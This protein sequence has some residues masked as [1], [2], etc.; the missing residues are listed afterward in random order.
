[1]GVAIRLELL[2]NLLLFLV[3]SKQARGFQCCQARKRLIIGML[4]LILLSLPGFL[5]FLSK[6]RE[7]S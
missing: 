7:N 2:L 3:G 1:M 6:Q 4:S 5:L